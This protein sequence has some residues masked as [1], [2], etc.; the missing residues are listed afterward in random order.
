MG[1]NGPRWAKILVTSIERTDAL[2]K[3]IKNILEVLQ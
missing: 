2:L 1:Q 3:T